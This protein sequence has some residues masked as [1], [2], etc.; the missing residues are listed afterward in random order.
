MWGL[1]GRELGR[2]AGRGALRWA[3]HTVWGLSRGSRGTGESRAG[4]EVKG[5]EVM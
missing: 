3:M 1:G 4:L 2:D 5:G